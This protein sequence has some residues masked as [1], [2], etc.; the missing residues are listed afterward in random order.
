MRNATPIQNG[1]AHSP[2]E[3][4]APPW[5]LW[6]HDP[7]EL[8]DRI[9]ATRG[10]R[11]VRPGMEKT[12]IG[13]GRW[14]LCVPRPSDLVVLLNGTGRARRRP[15]RVAAMASCRTTY[16]EYLEYEDDRVIRSIRRLY[17]P[18]GNSRP[19]CVLTADRTL[20]Q[21]LAREGE[22][23]LSARSA[24]IAA[25]PRGSDTPGAVLYDARDPDEGA[26]WLGAI[27][28]QGI[29]PSEAL[30]DVQRMGPSVWG[31]AC[32][33]VPSSAR[34]AGPVFLGRG[35]T[36][37][38]AAV[39][40]G[41]AVLPDGWAGSGTVG[42]AES[43]R[44]KHE[45]HTPRARRRWYPISKRVFD[46]VVAGVLIV[47]AAPLMAA[48][49]LAIL[50][51]DRAPILFRQ[52]RQ[53]GGGREFKC[54]KFRTM[55]RNADE[56]QE[57]LRQQNQNKADGPQ[58]AMDDDPRILR[59]GHWLRRTQLDELP[60][61][62]NVVRGEMSL[63]GPRPSPDHENQCCPAWREAR[64]SVPAGITGLW[65]V[66]RRREPD[67]DFQEWIRY[68]IEYAERCCWSMDLRILLET[69][70]LFVPGRSRAAK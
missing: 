29:D 8:H 31:S 13:S 23:A 50:V 20:G 36:L 22:R 58:F 3:A 56:L 61:L 2:A 38:D 16:H 37:P 68:D 25:I 32:A 41:P 62:W 11:V 7:V 57:E 45:T 28:D 14:Y 6:G 17:G 24:T 52:P 10:V 43:V 4:P 59:V 5:T 47:L 19:D 42:R 46:I 64:L 30:L 21:R 40:V 9:W 39:I 70:G 51:E 44:P 69:A 12:A 1:T 65:Q 60:Q 35:V 48:I 54:L 67:T 63:V 26:A 55:V 27:V 49:A 34:L 66:R 33:G 15:V 18:N 53:T